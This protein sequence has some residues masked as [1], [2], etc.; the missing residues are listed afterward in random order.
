MQQHAHKTSPQPVPY[1]F[2]LVVLFAV[3]CLCAFACSAQ[4]AKPVITKIDPPNWFTELPDSLL[5]V[6]GE[7]LEN[8]MFAVRSGD[9]RITQ[10]TISPNGHWAFLTFA[11][12]N[13]RPGAIEIAAT[14]SKGGTVAPYVLSARRSEAEQPKGFSSADVMYLI[15]PDR[16]ADG[17]AANDDLKSF[18]DPD[19]R[20][21]GFAYHGGDLRGITDHL[22]YLK[23][24]G[25]TTLWTTPLYDNS[26]GQTG[27]TYHGYS[28]TDMYAVD[29]HFGSMA[30]YRALVDAAH[31]H[32]MKVVL[33]TV[34]NHVGPAH[35][36]VKDEP[37][38]DW[39]HGT[40]ASH[41]R[42]DD[43]FAS[44]TDPT[45]SAARRHVLLDGWFADMLPD[46]N[47]DN[48][49]V[50]QYLAQNAIWW[51]ESAGLDGLRIDTFPYVQRSFW[52]YYNGALHTLYPNMTDVGEVF[53]GDPH[54]TSFFAGG[55][56]NLGS[57]G[58]YDTL[59]DTPFDYPMFF[60]L[61]GA[62]T[63]HKPMSAIA[64]VLNADKLYPH[65]ERLVTFLGN[66]DTR[67]FLSEPGANPAALH[68]AFGLLATLRGMPQLYYGDE[69]GMKGGEDD[70]SNRK[71][72]PGGF[73]KDKADAFTDAGRNPAQQAMHNWVETLMQLREHTSVLQ[74]GQMQ[75]LLADKDSLVFARTP[76]VAGNC[77]TAPTADRYVIVINNSTSPQDITVDTAANTV[78]G[79]T[80]YISA[81]QDGVTA[82]V[83]AGKLQ[84]HLP[85]QAIGIFRAQP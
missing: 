72:F 44:V 41:I 2:S 16:F 13:A 25:I 51:I 76:D 26:A 42:V 49:Y 74:T 69:I 11:T 84:I 10:T 62:L 54:I 17:D 82:Q 14:N 38:P 30:D 8:T 33:D 36:W 63:H 75:T 34:P 55:R 4:S 45:A 22:D 47:Q 61:R 20:S 78:T 7:H 21:A 83:T 1:L 9:A 81:L 73:L 67:R 15:M 27:Q 37:T 52:Q 58:S 5:L 85:G 56:A 57:D 3:Q 43:D 53:N 31:A 12:S 29:P 48:P 65:P 40:A 66:H 23:Q 79:C 28:A 35:P 60:A 46:L 32:G 39:F 70:P 64:D 50:A 24:M 68:L 80:H 59:L 6:H 18:R 71:D 19:D 77:M